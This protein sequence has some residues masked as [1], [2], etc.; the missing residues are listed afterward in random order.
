MLGDYNGIEL[1]EKIKKGQFRVAGLNERIVSLPAVWQIVRAA[2][3]QT[4]G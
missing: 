4:R 1:A 3:S 2:E